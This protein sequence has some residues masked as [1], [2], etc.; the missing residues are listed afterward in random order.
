MTREANYWTSTTMTGQSVGAWRVY[1]FHGMVGGADKEVSYH[2]RA[3]RGG[4]S[5]PPEPFTDNQDGTVTDPDTGLVWQ[6][7]SYGQV[8]DDDTKT[9]AGTATTHTWQDALAAAEE[10]D[11]AG[12][13]DWRLPDINELQTLVDDTKS[14]PAVVDLLADDTPPVDYWSSTTY[15]GGMHLA[16]TVF[17][18]NGFVK[19][20]DKAGTQHRVRAVRGGYGLLPGDAEKAQSLP[21]V[22]MLLLDD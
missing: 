22:F 9:C 16:W 7:C 13:T 21:G 12:H 20:K 17:F 4:P 10:L 2:V 1:F 15:H 18:H 14:F 8:W 6:R 19:V 3:V 5:G 11:W